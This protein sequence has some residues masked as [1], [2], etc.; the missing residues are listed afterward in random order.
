MSEAKVTR[1]GVERPPKDAP[2]ET[3][4]L[5]PSPRAS[6]GPTAPK[7][8]RPPV[9]AAGAGRHAAITRTLYNYASYKTWADKVKDTWE[10]EAAPPEQDPK[11]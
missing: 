8:A 5:R 9:P 1:G 3:W 6:L 11:D 4:R 2:V 10:P 7:G